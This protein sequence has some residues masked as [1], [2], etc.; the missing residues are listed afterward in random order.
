MEMTEVFIVLREWFS[1]DIAW[2]I[3]EYLV[4]LYQH[5]WQQ[6]IGIVNQEYHSLVDTK[7]NHTI[8]YGNRIYNYRTPSSRHMSICRMSS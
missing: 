4:R 5:E 8:R 3:N 1:K 2:L 7:P 6:Q